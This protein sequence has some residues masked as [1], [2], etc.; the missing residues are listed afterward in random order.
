MFMLDEIDERPCTQRTRQID[1]AKCSH[2]DPGTC[3]ERLTDRDEE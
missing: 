2:A 3:H 1:Y